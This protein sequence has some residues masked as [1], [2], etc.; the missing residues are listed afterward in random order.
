[1]FPT[2]FIKFFLDV[3]FVWALSVFVMRSP[4][5]VNL[6]TVWRGQLLH[7]TTPCRQPDLVAIS[8]VINGLSFGAAA[9]PYSKGSAQWWGHLRASSGEWGITGS[10]LPSFPSPSLDNL[11]YREDFPQSTHGVGMT[12]VQSG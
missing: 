5:E 10:S 6:R 2:G 4:A 11:L 3:C 1:M 12:L 9:L 7:I 8:T